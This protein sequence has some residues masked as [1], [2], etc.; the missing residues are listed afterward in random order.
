MY[1]FASADHSRVVHLKAV[2]S[3]AP[4]R[5]RPFDDD[6]ITGGP[7]EMIVPH[8]FAGV[9]QG[10]GSA[11][12]RIDRTNAMQFVRVAA[13]TRPGEVV[14]HGS[15]AARLRTNVV[16]LERPRLTVLREP[17][18]LATAPRPLGDPTAEGS[19]Y[20]GHCPATT[21]GNASASD[22]SATRASSMSMVRFIQKSTNPCSSRRWPAFRRS[23]LRISWDI[24]CSRDSSSRYPANFLNAAAHSATAAICAG[25]RVE[26]VEATE[27]SRRRVRFRAPVMILTPKERH[28][29][30]PIAA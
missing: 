29:A 4:G 6:G 15:A 27:R 14:Q 5:R 19:R 25:F 26:R 23:L 7:P 3:R 9:K 16:N 10:N 8:L 1:E 13:G 20:P 2:N 30:S 18:I 17:A 12:G 22:L 24:R 28:H 21:S 11:R